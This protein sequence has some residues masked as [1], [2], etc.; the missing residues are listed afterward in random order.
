M[1]ARARGTGQGAMYR[2]GAL[3]SHRI[4]WDFMGSLAIKTKRHPIAP[5]VPA[6]QGV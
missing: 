2:K 4:P 5:W 3:V 1:H 6:G